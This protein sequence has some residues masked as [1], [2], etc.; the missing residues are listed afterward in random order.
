MILNRLRVRCLVDVSVFDMGSSMGS[1]LFGVCYYGCCF[2]L[3]FLGLGRLGLGGKKVMW[4]DYYIFCVNYK[5]WGCYF[6]CLMDLWCCVCVEVGSIK[7]R[8]LMCRFFIV[9]FVFMFV[10]VVFG[11]FYWEFIKINDFFEG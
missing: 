1:L 3:V 10:G 2:E 8:N 6:N 7:E 9:V 5:D 11:F 4:L